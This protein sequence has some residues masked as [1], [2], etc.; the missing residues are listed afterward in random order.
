V[1][2]K[3]PVETCTPVLR[4]REALQIATLAIA[5]CPSGNPILRKWPSGKTNPSFLHFLVGQEPD[6][7]FIMEI[8]YIDSVAKWIAE[9]AA[10]A[11]NEL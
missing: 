6:K 11:W 1:I 10:K 7:R 2:P 5:H 8:D 9:N 4:T 3:R